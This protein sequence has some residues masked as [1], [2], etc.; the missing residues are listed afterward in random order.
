MSMRDENAA[1]SIVGYLFS[2][3]IFWGGIGWALDSWLN[4][5]YLRI[6]GLLVGTCASLYLVWLR[7]GRQ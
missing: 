6:V 4:T 3:M 5:N 1:W 2:G 7:Y